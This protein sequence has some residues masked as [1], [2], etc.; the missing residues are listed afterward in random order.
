MNSPRLIATGQQIVSLTLAALVTSAVL[1]SLAAQADERH[2]DALAQVS[3]AARLCATPA[4][5]PALP[6]RQAEG[7][8]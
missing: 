5:Q 3:P 2:A 8:T 7:R 6:D 1:L 4:A